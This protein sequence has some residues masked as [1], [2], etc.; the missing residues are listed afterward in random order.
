ML[1]LLRLAKCIYLNFELT[2]TENKKKGYYFGDL[3]L[4]CFPDRELS[5]RVF[6]SRLRFDNARVEL[7][8]ILFG[9]YRYTGRPYVPKGM[10]RFERVSHCMHTDN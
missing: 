7:K 4:R 1:P 8:T 10:K 2:Y 5:Q 3:S 6:S 9:L